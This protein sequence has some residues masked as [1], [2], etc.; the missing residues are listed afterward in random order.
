MGRRVFDVLS[1]AIKPK[2]MPFF[3]AFPH[4]S[5]TIKKTQI[6]QRYHSQLP[7]NITDRGKYVTPTFHCPENK[8]LRC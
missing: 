6:S 1:T 5:V 8:I 2:E 3:L 4:L 7:G